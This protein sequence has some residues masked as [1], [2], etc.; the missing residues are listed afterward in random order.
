MYKRQVRKCVKD[1]RDPDL[2]TASDIMTSEIITVDL[3]TSSEIAIKIMGE[4][5]IRHLPVVDDQNKLLNFISHRDL[6][7]SVRGSTKLNII[8][9]TF[10]CMIIPIVFLVNSFGWI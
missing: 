3:K 8:L 2:V 5:N 9:I 6:I 1:G 7:S 4:N 10:I